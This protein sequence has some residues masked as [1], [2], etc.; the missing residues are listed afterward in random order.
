MTLGGSVQK[1]KISGRTGDPRHDPA[2]A[3]REVDM[4]VTV[5]DGLEIAGTLA[6]PAGSEGPRPAVVLLWP[7]RLDRE[8]NTR[9]A[10]LDLGRA[11]AAALAAKGVASYRFD[12]RGVGETGGDWRRAGFFR[13]RADAAAVLRAL[14]AR[15]EVRG[16]AVGA[17]GYS[18]GAL[19]AAWLGAYAAPPCAAVVLLACPAQRGD[20]FYLQWAGR[21]GKQQVPWWLRLALRPL[22]RT[23]R[24]QVARVIARIKATLEDV[25]RI[26]GFFKVPARQLRE[27]LGYNPRPDMQRISVP[28]LAVTGANDI[29][30]D[31]RDLDVIA[32]LVPGGAET[33][34]IERLT[35]LLRRD[36]R[37]ASPKTYREQY[38][39]PVDPELLKEVAAWVGETLRG[40]GAAAR[41]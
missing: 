34:R 39:L 38:K 35:H 19:H 26:Y 8:G 6:L 15:P 31:P 16:R 17:I 18:E 29:S 41:K 23:P 3:V 32:R 12:R 30:V 2:G 36:R 20:D 5:D 22:G 28:V 10:P 27:Y 40:R 14:A 13:H 4:A 1:D 11:M 24:D 9:K 7:G 21:L 37:A 25:E 33:R